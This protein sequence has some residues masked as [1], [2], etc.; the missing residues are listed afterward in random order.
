M[1]IAYRAGSEAHVTTGSLTIAIPSGVQAGDV[2]VLVGGQNDAG[3]SAND[4]ATPAGWTPIDSRRVGTNLFGAI[5]V[6]VAQSGDAG[7]SVALPTAGTGKACALLA[8]YSGCDPVTPVNVS[9]ALS[10]SVNTAS[11]V[12]PTVGTALDDTRVVIACAQSNSVAEGWGTASG[13]TKRL[14]SVGFNSAP[15]GHVTATLQDKAAATVGTYGGEALVATAVST[16][17][18]MWTVALS[19]ASSTQVSRPVSDLTIT[20]AE[21]VPAPGGG[22][23]VYAR[24]AE[25]VDT[26]YAQISDDG[27]VQAGVASL[28][29]PLSATGHKVIYRS[30]Y[31]GG[32][33][34]GSMTVT[35]K[36]GATTV[37][38]WTDTL[39]GSFQTFTHTLTSG[40]AN[41]ITDYAGL[42]V[43][44][45]PSLT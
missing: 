12:T 35:L 6:R 31:A 23:G 42:N 44:F 4:W 14:D 16:K 39:T 40:E 28:V 37:A 21:G 25:N 33:S 15:S 34:A 5:W 29:D 8:A 2:M 41:S 36:Q 30:C 11:H 13:Y 32:A 20:D 9:A 7:G 27:V 38:S 19:P 1:A 10:E 24:L 17:A 18:A 3:V 26:S 43:T 22:S 45:S